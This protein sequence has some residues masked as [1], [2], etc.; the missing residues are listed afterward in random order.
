MTRD[1]CKLKPAYVLTSDLGGDTIFDSVG[2]VE[3][4]EDEGK[5]NALIR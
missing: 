4:T 2:D 5:V 3:K 1:L